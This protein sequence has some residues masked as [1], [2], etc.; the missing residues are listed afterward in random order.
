MNRRNPRPFDRARVISPYQTR[1]KRAGGIKTTPAM[2][3]GAVGRV[4]TLTELVD[5]LESN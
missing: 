2:A 4:W 5:L 3:V 1:A